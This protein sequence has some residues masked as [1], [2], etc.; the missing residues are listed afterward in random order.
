[1]KEVSLVPFEEID[2]VK[3]NSCVHYA[4]NGNIFGYHW[5]LTNAVRHWD[6]LVYDDYETIF[7]FFF[8]NTFPG[9]KELYQPLL[10]GKLGVYSVN[11]VTKNK[12]NRMLEA[13]PDTYQGMHVQ[14]NDI[15]RLDEATPLQYSENKDHSLY[16]KPSDD[17]LYGNYSRQLK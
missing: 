8:R 2:K 5:Y 6:A 12:V 4:V 9:M 15:N 17:Q 1:M 13:I 3:W 10:V 7:F 14:L 16:L 11:M